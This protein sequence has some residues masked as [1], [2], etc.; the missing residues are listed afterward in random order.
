MLPKDNLHKITNS[1]TG[2]HLGLALDNFYELKEQG[3]K[4]KSAISVILH[5]FFG[6]E[7]AVNMIGYEVFDNKESYQ[8]MKENE[9]DLPLKKMIKSWNSNL[10]CS[11][12]LELIIF[13]NKGSLPASLKNRF[14]EL[15]SLRNWLSHG[16]S[17]STT[18]LLQPI[19]GKDNSYDVIDSEDEYDWKKKFPI[20][21]FNSL[22]YLDI[23][24]AEKALRIVFEILIYLS[25][26]SKHFI[27]SVYRDYGKQHYNLIYDETDIN[28][29]LKTQIL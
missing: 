3:K 12:K 28:E 26:L 18:Y 20:C 10:P 6:L 4:S 13:L 25:T 22:V 9:R 29:L 21:K 19:E 8:Y 5:A 1:L 24:D 11:E 16:F 17:Y 2:T 23:G 15:N 14:L 7:S 27:F